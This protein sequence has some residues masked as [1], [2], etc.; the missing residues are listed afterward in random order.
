MKP[1]QSVTSFALSRKREYSEEA[2]EP[3]A[4]TEG[5]G[6]GA[7]GTDLC[8]AQFRATVVV[9]FIPS[10]FFPIIGVQ[11]D[12]PINGARRKRKFGHDP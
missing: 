4:E 5:R 3:A 9:V 1:G 11:F 12:I 8:G 7:V 10:F 6:E 2:V